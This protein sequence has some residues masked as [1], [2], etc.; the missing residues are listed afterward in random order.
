VLGEPQLSK[1]GLYP[2]ISKK[3]KDEHVALMTNFISLCDGD[4]SLLDIAERLKIP[5]WNLYNIIDE[6]RSHELIIEI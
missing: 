5:A 2:F 4:T 1:R 3:Y 6:L